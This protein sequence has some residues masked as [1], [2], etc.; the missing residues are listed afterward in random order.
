MRL[1][2][3]FVPLKVVAKTD[4]LQASETTPEEEEQER[5]TSS[6]GEFLDRCPRSSVLDRRSETT[7][8]ASSARRYPFVVPVMA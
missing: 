1:E 5:V 6:I 4:Q 2:R 7:R 8:S 3:L